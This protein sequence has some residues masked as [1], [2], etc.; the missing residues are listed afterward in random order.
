[1]KRG[2]KPKPSVTFYMR[3]SLYGDIKILFSY[4]GE[5][6]S[7]GSTYISLMAEDFE[8]LKPT[9]EPKNPNDARNPKIANGIPVSDLLIHLGRYIVGE[10]EERLSRGGDVDEAYIRELSECASKSMFE[11]LRVW[12]GN[13]EWNRGLAKAMSAG[14]E[15]VEAFLSRSLS[16]MFSVDFRKDEK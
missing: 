5:R 1:M 9:G 12:S 14:S 15:S 2:R 7:C 10:V 11:Q 6:Y 3:S 16:K 4:N 8:L 13:I